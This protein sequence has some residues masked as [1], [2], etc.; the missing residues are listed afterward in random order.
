MHHE[1]AQQTVFVGLSGGVDSSVAAARLIDSGFNVVGVFIEVWTPPFL[2]CDQKEDRLDAMRTAAYL[3]IPFLI[4][5]AKETYKEKVALYMVEEYRKGRTPNPDAMCNEA[6]KFGVFLDFAR[7]HKADYVA[8]GHYAQVSKTDGEYQL[9]RGIDAEKDQSYFLYRLSQKELAHT[10]FP[11]G[12]SKKTEVRAEAQKRGL[13][14]AQRR[15]S[16]GICFLGAVDMKEF[17]SH[18]IDAKEGAVLD[19]HGAVIGSHDGAH[20]YTRGQRHGFTIYDAQA[21][22]TP[23]YVIH[24]N[25]ETNTLVVDTQHPTVKEGELHISGMHWIGK[26]LTHGDVCHIQT[27]YRQ[28]PTEVRI[29]AT[30]DNTLI[31]EPLSE[32]EMP[33]TGQ[34]AVLYQGQVCRGGG[35]I[36]AS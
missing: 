16:Q 2:Q 22:R 11:L 18:Y 24:K 19:V 4:C 9:L 8:T 12:E 6:V 25:I 32:M 20:F 15:D 28:K 27:R 7:S 31:A 33:T 34:S 3:G 30:D 21:N 35:M 5:D 17:L 14:S 29:R 26:K 13:P 10:I 23:H 1:N 36:E